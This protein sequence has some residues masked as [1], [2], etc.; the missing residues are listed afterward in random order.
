MRGAEVPVQK[1]VDHNLYLGKENPYAVP[2]ISYSSLAKVVVCRPE[3]G[4]PI[5]F[6]VEGDM[7]KT[8]LNERVEDDHIESTLYPIRGRNP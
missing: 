7:Q 8:K 5:I 4:N 2:H 1:V 3:S 6:D